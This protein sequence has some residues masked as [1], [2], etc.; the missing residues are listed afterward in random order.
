MKYKNDKIRIIIRQN[1]DCDGITEEIINELNK[2]YN[3]VSGMLFDVS[4]GQSSYRDRHGFIHRS[5]RVIGNHICKELLRAKTPVDGDILEAMLPYKSMAMHIM[6]RMVNYDVYDRRYLENIYYRHLKYWNEILEK[7]HISCVLFMIT[8][9]HVGE[10]IL[11]ALC[12]IKNIPIVMLYQQLHIENGFLWVMGNSIETM[13]ESI[14]NRYLE[15]KNQVVTDKELSSIM[16]KIVRNASKQMGVAISSKKNEQKSA[17]ELMYKQISLY[18]IARFIGGIVIKELQKDRIDANI[19]RLRLLYA[20]RGRGHERRMDHIDDY[21]K[22]A[23]N[24]RKGE[25]YIYYALHMTPECSTMP[26]AGEFRNQLLA[27][28]LIAKAAEENGLMLYVKEH[29]VQYNREPGFYH[30]INN[31]KNVKLINMTYSS[32]ELIKQAVAVVSLTGN[33]MFEAMINGK[34][35]VAVGNGYTFKKMPNLIEIQSVEECSVVLND[36]LGGKRSFTNEDMYR[37]LKA[38][39]DE[40]FELYL[41]DMSEVTPAYNKKNVANIIADYIV[42][43][44]G[45]N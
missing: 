20:L 17:R 16:Q 36:I 15:L 25:R 39:D 30:R 10:Y 4:D 12:K 33:V 26:V 1:N 32:V 43:T 2:R 13:G 7:N 22:F 40:M 31:I 42:Q 41:D 24:P 5:N 6:M 37:Y 35:A 28:E 14:G 44:K 38:M 11:Y 34:N 18:Q 21:N 19:I 27:I 23:C 29:Y 9:H 8:P 3:H 45:N